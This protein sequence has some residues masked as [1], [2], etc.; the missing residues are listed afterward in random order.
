MSDTKMEELMRK[1]SKNKENN[2][3]IRLRK[4]QSEYG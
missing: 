2:Y 4:L 1:V 3:E